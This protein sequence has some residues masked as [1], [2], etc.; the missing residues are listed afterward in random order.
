MYPSSSLREAFPFI[1]WVAHEEII[2]DLDNLPVFNSHAIEASLNRIPGRSEYFIYF[3]DDVFLSS[4]YYQSDFYDNARRSI[5]YCEQYGMVSECLNGILEKVPNYLQASLNSHNLMRSL[6]QG[7]SFTRLHKHVP[8]ALIKSILYDIEK[9]FH[10]AVSITCSAKLL[11]P[12]DINIV[13]FLYH[14]YS[15][16]KR[17]SVACDARAI[18]VRP[19][20][21][22]RFLLDGPE[23]YKFVCF[24]DGGVSSADDHYKAKP[25]S[26]ISRRFPASI[27]IRRF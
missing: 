4:P 12:R 1:K 5:S 13:S 15:F 22:D 17:A 20:N 16:M 19:S 9:D 10:E 23:S 2:P 24:N 26:Y 8:H 7:Q 21:I 18:I 6:Y 3:N 25:L 14:H 11:S 27:S